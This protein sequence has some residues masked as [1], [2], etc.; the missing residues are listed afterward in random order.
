MIAAV[1]LI[2]LINFIGRRTLT[3]VSFF[4]TSVCL[5]VYQLIIALAEGGEGNVTF[6]ALYTLHD[7]K[8]LKIR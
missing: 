6:R 5:L 2:I 7:R 4:L 8:L 1:I 3:S